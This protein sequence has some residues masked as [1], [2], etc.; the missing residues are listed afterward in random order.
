M[1]T[2]RIIKHVK[3]HQ[4]LFVKDVMN[5]IADFL[6]YEDVIELYEYFR[7]EK[8]IMP[9]FLMSLDKTFEYPFNFNKNQQLKHIKNIY[10]KYE[11]E[12]PI[13]VN[14]LNRLGA[15]SSLNHILNLECPLCRKFIN[16]EPEEMSWTYYINDGKSDK[17]IEYK[18][19]VFEITTR[20]YSLSMEALG[21]KRLQY[22]LCDCVI[23]E[24]KDFLISKKLYIQPDVEL[25][26][27]LRNFYKCDNDSC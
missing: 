11:E 18:Y 20:H 22:H 7:I 10:V 15:F 9:T 12:Y 3:K 21:I 26:E 27:A 23:D 1:T 25:E 4:I 16:F 24:F 13:T 5:I 2:L 6:Q 19:P 8:P 17:H 14:F